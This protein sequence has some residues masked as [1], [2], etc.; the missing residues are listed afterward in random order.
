VKLESGF[1]NWFTIKKS[2]LEEAGF[3]IFTVRDFEK[4]YAIGVY[5]GVKVKLSVNIWV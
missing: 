4:E 5:L 1:N 3:V 2:T